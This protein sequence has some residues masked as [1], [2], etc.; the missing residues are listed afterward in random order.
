MTIDIMDEILDYTDLPGIDGEEVV[1]LVP[2]ELK[3]V[4]SNPDN[5]IDDLRDDYKLVRQNMHYQQQMLF[6]VAKA[7]L[8]TAKNSETAKN[9]DAFSNLMNQFS[10][11]NEKLLKL[12]KEM[13]DITGEVDKKTPQSSPVNISNANVFVGGPTDIMD[14][15][16]DA[17]EA[18]HGVVDEQ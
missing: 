7:F 1:T 15:Y 16:G 9:I 13:R 4:E 3:E 10:A 18:V 6:D 8:E 14:Q 5:R 12:H 2:L 17:F 11:S